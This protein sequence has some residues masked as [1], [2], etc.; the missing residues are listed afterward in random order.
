VSE[1]KILMKLGSS[2]VIPRRGL[3]IPSVVKVLMRQERN[4]QDPVLRL[5]VP[6][7][8]DVFNHK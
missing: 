3:V 1:L 6:W 5:C 4:I 8:W 2:E 7:V